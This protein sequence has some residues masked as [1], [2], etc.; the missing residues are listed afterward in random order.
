MG[1]PTTAGG[2]PPR[3]RPTPQALRALANSAVWLTS[4]GAW[5]FAAVPMSGVA[6]TG[7]PT[8]RTAWSAARSTHNPVHSLIDCSHECVLQSG[9]DTRAQGRTLVRGARQR[10]QEELKFQVCKLGAVPEVRFEA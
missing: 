5:Y 1:L 4:A 2:A 9:A 3:G 10:H 7:G 8:V 6:C